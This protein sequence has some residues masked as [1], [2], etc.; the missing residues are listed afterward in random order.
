MLNL[1][2]IGLNS[3]DQR[4][5]DAAETVVSAL[6]L[7]LKKRTA[8]LPASAYEAVQILREYHNG[9]GNV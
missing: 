1:A 4:I 8:V 6:T 3:T 9:G 2:Q 5:K 7:H